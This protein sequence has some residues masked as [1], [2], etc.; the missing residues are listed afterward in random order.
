MFGLRRALALTTAERYFALILSF[1]LMSILSRLMTPAEIGVYVLANAIMTSFLA[2]REFSTT[3]YLVQKKDL[4]PAD[5]QTVFTL[6]LLFSIAIAIA[7]T[8]SA[9]M[10]ARAF[11]EP[12]L[13]AYL[14]VAAICIVIEGCGGPVNAL[15][16][17]RM[18]YAKV[19]LAGIVNAGAGFIGTVLLAL[20]GFGYM[21]FVGGWMIGATATTLCYVLLW[22]DRSLYRPNVANWRQVLEF[23]SYNGGTNVLGQVV[24]AL[25]Y[26]FLGRILPIDA[27]ALYNRSLTICALP[28][29]VIFGGVLNVLISAF[30]NHSRNGGDLKQFYLK[31]VENITALQWP[32]LVMIAILAHPIVHVLLGDQWHATIPLIQIIA[33]ASL[34]K[35]SNDLN[36][37]LLIACGAS[38]DV[39]IKSLIVLPASAVILIVAATWGLHAAAWSAFIY[40]PF[41]AAVA[42]LFNRRHIAFTWGELAHAM[43]KAPLLAAATAAGPMLVVFASGTFDLSVFATILTVG[44]AATGWL[45][46]I[47]AL[48]HPLGDEI[49]R[50]VRAIDQRMRPAEKAI[51]AN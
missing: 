40:L 16:R 25:P 46:A 27:L 34:F 33:F 42:I 18:D 19:A 12:R 7:M 29:K 24:E 2:L 39:F 28:D 5:E 44:L 49:V 20:L 11:S 22:P 1:A 36:Y 30:S 47:W 9:S 38:R 14:E 50:L 4:Q 35:F 21:S 17:R 3:T 43:R 45:L 48:N 31:S 26:M 51:S 6:Q 8:G 32:A 23:G 41:Q 37:P 10:I 13:V 15:L